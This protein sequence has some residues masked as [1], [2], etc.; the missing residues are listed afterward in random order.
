M[1]HTYDDH[2]TAITPGK[3]LIRYLKPSGNVEWLYYNLEEDPHE[4]KPIDP[5]QGGEAFQALKDSIE[6]FLK[7]R[8][9]DLE[10]EGEI[11][12]LSEERIQRM[13]EL[14]YF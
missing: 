5:E 2:I 9:L 4:M 12:P 6:A 14:G 3:K 8:T 7:N 13:R 11:I 1:I 10:G